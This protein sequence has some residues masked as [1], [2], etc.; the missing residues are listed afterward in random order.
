MKEAE[1]QTGILL[2]LGSRPDLCRIWRANTGKA[3]RRLAGGGVQVVT[4]GVIGQADLSGLLVNGR[5]LEIE[6][7]SATG[8]QRPEQ[9]NY[10][11]MIERFGGLYVLARSVEEAVQ[12]VEGAVNGALR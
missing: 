7:K 12:A 4:F 11:A 3:A 9:K 6:V 1:I 5:R 10:Q 8:K 2:A